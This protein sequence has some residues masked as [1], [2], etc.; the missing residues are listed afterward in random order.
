ME[1]RGTSSGARRRA[2]VVWLALMAG[3]VLGDRLAPLGFESWMWYAAG[4]ALAAGGLLIRGAAVRFAVS[5]AVSGAVAGAVVALGAGWMT[6]R[7]IERPGDAL[8]RLVA[9]R[10]VAVDAAGRSLIE[11]EVVVTDRPRPTPAYWVEPGAPVFGGTGWSGEARVTALGSEPASGTIGLRGSGEIPQLEPGAAL[12][13]A[14]WYEPP[15]GAL[16]PGAYRSDRWAAATGRV[17]EIRVGTIETLD[18]A[19]G[20][21]VLALRGWLT[22]R[23][24][25]ALGLDAAELGTDRAVVAAVTLGERGPE[26]ESTQRRSQQTG[27]AHLLAISGFHMVVMASALLVALRITGDRGWVEP[28][29]VALVLVVYLFVAPARPSVVRAAVMV[30]ALLASE[31]SGRRHDRAGVVA[32]VGIA[33][34]LVRPM[35]VYALGY[36]LSFGLALALAWLGARFDGLLWRRSPLDEPSGSLAASAWRG[37]QRTVSAGVLCW[38]LSVPV[39]ALHTG[40]VGP[41]G[42]LLTLVLL[43]VFVPMVWLGFAAVLLGMVWPGLAQPLLFGADACA[44]LVVLIVE[45]AGSWAWMRWTAP[46]I[47][48]VSAAVMVGACVALVRG[49]G[50]VRAVLAVS[51]LLGVIA[52]NAVPR[53]SLDR[54]VVLRIDTLAVGNGTCHL[55]RSGDE[56]ILWD[57]GSLESRIGARLVP[58]ALRELGVGRVTTAVI[59]HANTDHYNGVLLASERLGIERVLVG[60][61]FL[62]RVRRRPEGP[63]AATKRALESAGVVFE[64]IAAGI[65]IELGVATIEIVAPAQ[66]KELEEEND[67][68]LVAVVSCETEDGTKSV[69]L[70]GDIQ[71]AGIG[72][73]RE[74][75]ALAGGAID[76]LELPHHGSFNAAARDFVAEL[77]PAVV[78]QSTGVARLNDERWAEARAAA[79]RWL[80][81]AQH[82]A[83]S[84]R[85]HAGGRVEAVGFGSAQ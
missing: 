61:S 47:G 81:T 18:A 66:P 82:G 31:A 28:A 53:S 45:V 15:R 63:A 73:L 67:R 58:S 8:D 12:R 10:G 32:W 25:D 83:I 59:T 70:T 9:E 71:A 46:P 76:V 84:T 21:A 13:I 54:G 69:L 6:Q 77:A 51:V 50:R 29:A 7:A 19:R 80:I 30:L 24:R 74:S 23:S 3:L 4:C 48:V 42:W 85:I 20:S 41:L 68:S 38:L 36:Q 1:L 17:G 52:W 11:I 34:L 62:D 26:L 78:V 60:Q 75:G 5:G 33:L 49:G 35:D 27:V 55:I 64:T 43:P 16:N 72:A 79:R 2:C 40:E 22:Q 65:A 57:C 44:R 56:A 37:V 39:L 14:G